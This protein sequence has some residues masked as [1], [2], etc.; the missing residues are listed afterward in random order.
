M[1]IKINRNTIN[2]YLDKN[3]SHNL[4][5][6]HDS[7]SQVKHK[8]YM[9]TYL[10]NGTTQHNWWDLD[11][12]IDMINAQLNN[13]SMSLPHPTFPHDPFTRV[14]YNVTQ[15]KQLYKYMPSCPEFKVPIP[16][17][18]LLSF[19]INN[20][21]L[22]REH[23]DLITYLQCT[24]NCR[25]K[26][27]NRK[28]SQNNYIGVWV[29]KSMPLSLFEQNYNELKLISPYVN[30]G[31]ITILNPLYIQ[32]QDILNYIPQEEDWGTARPP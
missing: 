15:L 27:F 28:D 5:G 4:L 14:P 11:I 23:T 17:I 32:Y 3:N 13:S 16:L 8:V 18:H 31:N 2:D 20:D 22:P 24:C 21:K 9:P 1:K 26:L 10:P 6:I 30:Y 29:N 12:F 7:W 25:Y 19:I